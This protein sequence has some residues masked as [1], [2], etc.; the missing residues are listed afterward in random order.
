MKWGVPSYKDG[1]YYFVALKGHVNLGFSL[2][3]LGE[4]ER[5]LFDGGGTTMKHLKINTIKQI[6]LNRII[7]LLKLV[8]KKG[9]HG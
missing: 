5:A 1:A 2:E 7:T 3:G 9:D 4:K 6:D 8:D